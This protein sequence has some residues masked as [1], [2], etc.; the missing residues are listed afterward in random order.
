MTFLRYSLIQIVAYGID[1]GSFLAFYKT[2]FAGPI[3]SN[4]GSK[5][6]AGAFAFFAHRIFTFAVRHRTA[7]GQ[8]LV[9]YFAALSLNVPLSSI[10][11]AGLLN[12]LPNATLAKVLAD[13]LCV[14]ISFSV[15]KFFV[16]R[17]GRDCSTAART[18]QET[19]PR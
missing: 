12:W 13:I 7:L 2:G 9:R 3:W 10:I 16:F 5:V 18:N 1:L 15:A 6:A 14:G 17:H 8:Q 19:W 4:I 11:L